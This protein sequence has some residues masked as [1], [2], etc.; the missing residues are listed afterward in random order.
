MVVLKEFALYS[1]VDRYPLSEEKN[2]SDIFESF[3][4][5]LTNMLLTG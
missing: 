4:Y 1:M 5:V 2:K 3:G